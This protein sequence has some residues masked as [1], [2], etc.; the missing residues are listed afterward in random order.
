MF[1]AFK[2]IFNT[3]FAADNV[4]FYTNPKTWQSLKSPINLI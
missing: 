2:L 3:I 1:A 4:D